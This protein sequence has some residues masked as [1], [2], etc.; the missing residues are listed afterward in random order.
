MEAVAFGGKDA[1]ESPNQVKF[2]PLFVL[3]F[4]STITLK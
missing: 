4:I 3:N 2:E 1:Q